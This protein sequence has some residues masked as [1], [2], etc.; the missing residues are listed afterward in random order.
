L[1][2]SFR[3][4]AQFDVLNAIIIVNIVVYVK[5]NFISIVVNYLIITELK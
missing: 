1:A 3:S 2:L 5:L 4:G